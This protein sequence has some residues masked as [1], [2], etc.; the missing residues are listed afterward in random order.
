MTSPDTNQERLLYQTQVNRALANTVRQSILIC[1]LAH[2]D[3]GVRT[4][5]IAAKLGEAPANV[6]KGLRV[7]EQAALVS[8]IVTKEVGITSRYYPTKQSRQWFEVAYGRNPASVLNGLVKEAASRQES[9]LA[10]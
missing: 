2:G 7:L 3:E 9:H 5:E 1:V 4:A 6:S 8:N 10:S